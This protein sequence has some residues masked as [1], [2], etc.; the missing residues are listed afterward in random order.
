MYVFVP[1]QMVQTFDA[2]GWTTNAGPQFV[3]MFGW[4]FSAIHLMIHVEIL[5]KSS[6]QIRFL[7]VYRPPVYFTP[8]S[9]ERAPVSCFAE[10]VPKKRKRFPVNPPRLRRLSPPTTSL[11]A[12]YF[13][14]PYRSPLPDPLRLCSI[15]GKKADTIDGK[16]RSGARK[17]AQDPHPFRRI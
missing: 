10:S 16:A 4:I 12:L 1:F 14:L 7:Q 13:R 6:D 17:P 15:T 3:D 11:R 2:Y 8:K 9:Q 5:F